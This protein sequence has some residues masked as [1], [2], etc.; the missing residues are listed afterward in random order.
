MGVQSPEKG[1]KDV[2]RAQASSWP[3]ANKQDPGG[4]GCVALFDNS[5]SKE[6]RKAVW[7]GEGG[8]EGDYEGPPSKRMRANMNFSCPYRK[9]NPLRFNVR[10]HRFCATLSF[11][12]M[13]LLK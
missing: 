11:A 5:N 7:N 1:A 10:D 12:D 6:K 2:P 4:D 9:R 13:N 8:N 3:G